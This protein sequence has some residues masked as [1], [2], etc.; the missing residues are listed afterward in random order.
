MQAVGSDETARGSG[1]GTGGA[2]NGAGGADKTMRFSGRLQRAGDE[3]G[4]RG[5]PEAATRGG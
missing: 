4:R 3:R 5:P 2:A 1:S